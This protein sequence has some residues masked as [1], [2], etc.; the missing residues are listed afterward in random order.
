LDE[1]IN[2]FIGTFYGILIMLVM[3]LFRL[4]DVCNKTVSTLHDSLCNN[5]KY[6]IGG[7]KFFLRKDGIGEIINLI[8]LL[9]TFANLPIRFNAR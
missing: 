5:E 6:L 4:F 3:L 2:H 8:E 1:I 9:K 7:Y